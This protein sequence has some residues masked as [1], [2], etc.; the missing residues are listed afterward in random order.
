LEG[1]LGNS[2]K[3]QLDDDDDDVMS[4]MNKKTEK[5]VSTLFMCAC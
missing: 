2:V 5:K 1:S 4:M 3:V